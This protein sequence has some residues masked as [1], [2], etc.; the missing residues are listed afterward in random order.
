[1][2]DRQ[3]I[4]DSHPCEEKSELSCEKGK[5]RGL[6]LAYHDNEVGLS[7]LTDD[8]WKSSAIK[9]KLYCLTKDT[10]TEVQ[11]HNLSDSIQLNEQS[12]ILD[13]IYEQEMGDIS[14]GKQLADKI[15][16][17]FPTLIFSEIA[18]KKLINEVQSQHLAA[19]KKKLCEIEN[20]FKNW[21]KQAIKAEDFR[22]KMTPQSVETLKK[23]KKE[24]SFVM[25]GKEVIASYHVRYTGGIPGRIYFHP[26]HISGKA[27]ICSLTTKLPT[28]TD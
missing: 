4:L 23:Y 16:I 17:Y 20:Y 21:D 3:I 11:I 22:S 24:H 19:I 5:C 28:V 2:C 25:D 13:L 14:T 10:S 27:L 9:G 26:D 1:M 6:L 7:L 8:F 18:I 15:H 12:K